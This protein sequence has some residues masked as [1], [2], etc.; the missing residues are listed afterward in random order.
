MTLQNK[1]STEH[2]ATNTLIELP[3]ATFSEDEGVRYLHL[4]TPLVQGAMRLNNP[5]VIELEYVQK[6]MSWM[7]FHDSPEHLV[8]LGLGCGTLAKFNH[9]HFPQSR[10]TA[11][12]LNSAVIEIGRTHFRLPQNSAH[13]HVEHMDA[14]DFILDTNNH[15]T[16]DI[17]QIDLY[18]EIADGPVFDSPEFYQASAACLTENGIMTTN[19]FGNHH[20]HEKNLDAMQEAFDAVV[21]FPP[22]DGENMIALA[23]KNSPVIDFSTLSQRASQIRRQ[24]GLFAKQWV[25]EL[26]EWMRDNMA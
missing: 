3:P 24:T 26:K 18:D 11:V 15:G 9:L 1:P 10:V 13:F 22:V 8:Q 25:I 19:L 5:D 12:E 7:L 20:C 17:L 6:M 16:V 21:W 23:F 4:G 2:P 14:Y